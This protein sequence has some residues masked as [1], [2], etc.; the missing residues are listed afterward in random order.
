[1]LFFTTWNESGSRAGSCL[2]PSLI[3]S[4]EYHQ[5]EGILLLRYSSVRAYQDQ[6]GDEINQ[7]ERIRQNS[8]GGYL[9]EWYHWWGSVSFFIK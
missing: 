5:R 9:V 6:T 2:T 8:A 4:A 1:M 7:A 3:P